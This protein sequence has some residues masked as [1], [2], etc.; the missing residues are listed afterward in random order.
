LIRI[1][2]RDFHTE[3]QR[4]HIRVRVPHLVLSI[5]VAGV[6]PQGIHAAI[7]ISLN[8]VTTPFVVG[9]TITWSASSW[10]ESFDPLQYRFSIT[11]QDGTMLAMR[12]F[13]PTNTL[14]WIPSDPGTYTLLATVRS[15]ETGELE[16]AQT[17]FTVGADLAS[18]AAPQVYPTGNPLVA[19]YSATCSSGK[20]HVLFYRSDQPASQAQSTPFKQCRANTNLAFIVAGMRG[21]SNYMLLNEVVDGVNSQRSSAQT[22]HT[23][24][25][26]QTL[27]ITPIKI[28]NPQT[29]ASS[30]AEQVILHSY[31]GQTPQPTAYDDRGNPIWYYFDPQFPYTVLFRPVPGGTFFLATPNGSRF[32]EIDLAGN[33]IREITVEEA[34]R[35]VRVPNFPKILGFSH[36][37][38]R[39]PDGSTAVIVSVEQLADQG[40]GTEDVDGD[41]ILVLDRNFRVAWTWNAFEKLDVKRKA[42]LRE[43]SDGPGATFLPIANDW[44][45]SNALVYTE[46]HNFLLSMRSQD[47]VIKIDYRDGGGTGDVVWRLGPGGD[48]TTDSTDPFPWFSH[49]HM[50]SLSNGIFTIFD[51]GNTRVNLMQGGNSRG[52]VW[53]IDENAR[54]AHLLLNVDLGSY[55]YALGSAQKLLNGNYEFLSGAIYDGR[56]Y[57]SE[58]TEVVSDTVSGTM[59][60]Q[61]MAPA[62][63]YRIYRMQDLYSPE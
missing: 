46:D 53:K 20:M 48:F 16:Q 50:P 61:F 40:T 22:Y 43:A 51:N 63:T 47:W 34:V 7:N 11:S 42:V 55:S 26:P 6:A 41:A 57:R 25:I 27:Q 36:D 45:H 31:A 44:M 14:D 23:G 12:T 59:N 13:G 3:V 18:L 17:T 54:T 30:P 15:A 37:A 58:A 32:R 62:Q 35:Q 39:L 8:S 21:D 5:L 24:S 1:L 10:Q 19:I 9:Q 28:R 56:M 2:K 4:V 52:Q 33:V 60:F 38:I 49:Q 29:I